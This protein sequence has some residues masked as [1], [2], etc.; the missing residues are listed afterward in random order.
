MSL[1]FDLLLFCYCSISFY[2]AITNYVT[3]G[4]DRSTIQSEYHIYNQKL[5]AAL[6]ARLIEQSCIDK[7]G[8]LVSL[9]EQCQVFEGQI[10]DIYNALP[11]VTYYTEMYASGRQCNQQIDSLNRTLHQLEANATINLLGDGYCQMTTDI[12]SDPAVL[13]VY[14]RAI[15]NGFDFYYYRFPTSHVVSTNGTVVTLSNCVPYIFSGPP[16]RQGYKSGIV[17]TGGGS[18]ESIDIGSNTVNITLSSGFQTIQLDDFQIWT[19]GL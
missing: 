8:Q 19:R 16:I 7:N 12:D 13:F 1:L 6:N 11:N 18:V 17:V 3:D 2:V 14:R 15:V 5:L 9:I 4:T 10:T